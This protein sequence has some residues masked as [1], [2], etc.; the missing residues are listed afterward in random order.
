MIEDLRASQVPLLVWTVNAH[1]P[2]SLTDHLAQLGTEGI[3]TDDPAGM[4]ASFG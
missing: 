2:G 3:I 4:L 1:G